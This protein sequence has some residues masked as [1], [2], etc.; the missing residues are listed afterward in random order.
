MKTIYLFIITLLTSYQLSLS[1]T[2]LSIASPFPMRLSGSSHPS[3]LNDQLREPIN[4]WA[5]NLIFSDNG[6]GIGGT[7][8]L[9]IKSDLSAFTSIFFSSAKDDR[10]FEYTDIYGNTYVPGKVNRLFMIPV[11]IGLQYRMFR[12]DVSD[13]LRPFVNAGL[14]PTA[15]IY[16]PYI[17]ALFPSLGYARAKYTL[18]GFVGAGMDY[19]TSKT[20]AVSLNVRYYYINLFGSGI[21]SLQNRPKNFFG[22]LYFVFSFNFLKR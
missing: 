18:G 2:P 8:Y 10:E 19:V 20:S 1:Q 9:P 11:N 13:N 21:E 16:T 5:I 14:T 12:E 15:I 7:Y 3:F 22:G 6:Y 4:N 17:K